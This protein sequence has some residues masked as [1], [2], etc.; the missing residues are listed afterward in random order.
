VIAFEHA[1]DPLF[2]LEQLADADI[3]CQDFSHGCSQEKGGI[4]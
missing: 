2:P 1:P 3:D 4:L